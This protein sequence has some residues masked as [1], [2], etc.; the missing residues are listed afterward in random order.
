MV[1]VCVG[2]LFTTS[3]HEMQVKTQGQVFNLEGSLNKL[4]KMTLE[5]KSPVG[6]MFSLTCFKCMLLVQV[7]ITYG[8][9]N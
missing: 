3:P 5:H 7:I 8:I 9:V 6:S 4:H 1:L 2:N